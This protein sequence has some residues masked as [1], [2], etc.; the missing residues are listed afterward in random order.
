MF[1]HEN[2]SEL[3]TGEKNHVQRILWKNDELGI[4]KFNL[5]KRQSSSGLNHVSRLK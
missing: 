1:T 2:F 4:Y 3:N 5:I